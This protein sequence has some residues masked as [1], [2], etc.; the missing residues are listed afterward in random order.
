LDAI[1]LMVEVRWADETS[2]EPID[3]LE[4]FNAGLDDSFEALVRDGRYGGLDALLSLLTFE[5]LK[6]DLNDVVY[7][8]RTAE[9]DFYPHQFLPVLNFVNSP[10][11]RLLIADEV[12]LGKTIEAAL[13]WTECQARFKSRRLL[14]ICPPTL[15]PKWIRELRDRF[16]IPAA[17]A[18]AEILL[19]HFGRFERRKS[20]HAF[21]LVTSYHALRPFRNERRMLQPWLSGEPNPRGNLPSLAEMP[22]RARLLRK[23]LEWNERE[24][25]A[26]MVVFDEAHL[27]KNTA[28]ASHVVGNVFASSSNSVLAL[29]ATPLTTKTRDLYALLKL[30]DPDMFRDEATFNLLRERNRPAV[31]LA[32]E[33]SRPDMNVARCR[34][35]IRE[36]PE[37]AARSHLEDAFSRID[38]AAVLPP[39]QRVELAAK[40][41]R[42]NELASFL[43]RT[44]KVEVVKNKVK[45]DAVTLNVTP[46]RE[47]EILYS[48][49]FRLI[50]SRVAERGDALS[51]FHLIGPAL[52]MTSC[53]PVIAR[54][55][56]DGDS[57]WGD[58]DDLTALENA[59][60]ESEAGA[61]FVGENPDVLFNDLSWLPDYDF[62][63]NDSKYDR[64]KR[65]LLDRTNDD[66]VI[67]FAFFK[68]TLYYL[69][70]RLERD[71]F[72]TKLVT[73]DITDRD[74]RDRALRSFEDPEVKVLL[75]SEVAAEGVDLQFCRVMVNYDLP[76]NPMR[77]EQRIGRIDRIGQ[78]ATTIVVINFHVR[79]TIDG[80]IY[81]HLHTNIGLFSETVGD[82]EGIIGEHLNAL[83]Q[84]LL[85]DE[86]TPSE[87]EERIKLT[88]L[89]I[90]NE[91]SISS[92]VTTESDS[93]LGLRTM[94]QD[95]VSQ[96]ESLGR[97]LK[98]I[99]LK[100]FTNEFFEEEYQGRDLCQLSPGTPE[101]D[102]LTV[103]LSPKAWGDFEAF[104]QRTDLPWPKNFD[105]QR[106]R[107]VMTFDPEIHAVRSRAIRGLV[108]ANH[109]HPFVQWISTTRR[110]S[111]K[112][113]HPAS[114]VFLRSAGFAEGS[115]LYLIARVSLKHS[116]LSK[117]SLIYR[118]IHTES[119]RMLDAYESEALI[120]T[121]TDGEGVGPIAS[122]RGYPDHSKH[123]ASL[124]SQ[125]NEDC[126]DRQMAFAEELELRINSKRAQINNHFRNRIENAEKRLQTMRNNMTG[127]EQ[128][129]R[130]VEGQLT[131]LRD[132][133]DEELDTLGGT[134]AVR[135]QFGRLA[136]GIINVIPKS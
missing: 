79:G 22:P 89:A 54:K 46:T 126:K 14:V 35:L 45:R 94:L 108:M 128:G 66:K 61:D 132:R 30:V 77:V 2:F 102:C 65:E 56:R 117:N 36:V 48:A 103:K 6:G 124:V 115:Y 111:S 127:R 130:L 47:E 59:Y 27:M 91:K 78:K 116:I 8:M 118:A 58:L 3:A 4:L 123:L 29:S 7:S 57:R 9:I 69:Q 125:T 93:L 13:I 106:R 64:L 75:C 114:A 17:S 72:T 33:L 32:N 87:I 84:T 68:E 37:S 50:R 31:L 81:Q 99:E 38:E 112:R 96:S 42:L 53:L 34:E 136:C 80:S 51:L 122:T 135:P 95:K 5:K 40:A 92:R 83:T 49:V 23:L 55:L 119:G 120:N 104:L 70:R 11:G 43:N 85:T 134:E 90:E 113:W 97:Y 74:E 107:A 63:A 20:G 100:R 41:Q 121:V 28:T 19:D 1:T 24:S 129:I 82:L 39:S 109:L 26:D 73:G 52:S 71:G 15:I 76:W 16:D 21:A 44:R 60:D 18:D 101:P 62:E 12:G 131:S 10:L 133:W 86:L 25:F 88:A 110:E 67:I 105:H 98:P